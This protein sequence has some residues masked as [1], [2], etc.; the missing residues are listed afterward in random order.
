MSTR[1]ITIKPGYHHETQGIQSRN[2]HIG[3]YSRPASSGKTNEFF[4]SYSSKVVSPEIDIFSELPKTVFDNTHARKFLG[5]MKRSL[6]RV[7]KSDLAGITLSKLLVTENTEMTL[8]I[9]WIYN[10]FRVYFSFDKLEGD[11]F[12]EVSNNPEAGRFINTFNKMN[13][14]DYSA[15]ADEEVSFVIRMARGDA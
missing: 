10:F 3:E 4:A 7:E 15:V 12:G 9:E 11:Y 8:V 1:T 6:L 2:I 13:E 5:E 14:S